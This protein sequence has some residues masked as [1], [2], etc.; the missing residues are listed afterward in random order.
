[1]EHEMPTPARPWLEPVVERW[2]LLL[3]FVASIGSLL[4]SGVL[5]AFSS[6]V[7]AG[8]ARIAPAQGI[9]AMQSINVTV[10]TTSFMLAFLGTGLVC[11]LLGA[12]SYFRRGRPGATLTA[13]ASLTY[14]VGC[15]GVTL[16][17]NVPLNDGLARVQSGTAD[18]TAYWLRFI[19]EWLAWNH[20]RTVASFA[21]GIFFV[22]ALIMR[23]AR[24]RRITTDRS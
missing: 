19:P 9:A 17:F 22:Y 6:F 13:V 3:T 15:I 7:I 16:A 11:V 10:I 5:F 18:A 8:L 2:A 14:V 12:S 20:V 4:V 24:P 21:A 23:L 1:M